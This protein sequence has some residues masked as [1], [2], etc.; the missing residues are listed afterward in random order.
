[1]LSVKTDVSPLRTLMQNEES[2]SGKMYKKEYHVCLLA[3]HKAKIFDIHDALYTHLMELHEDTEGI[4]VF[5]AVLVFKEEE[6]PKP[7]LGKKKI[8]DAFTYRY[9]SKIFVLFSGGETQELASPSEPL[10]EGSKEMEPRKI[11]KDRKQ[12]LHSRPMTPSVI[13]INNPSKS[14]NIVSSPQKSPESP[15]QKKKVY[16]CN[17]CPKEFDDEWKMMSHRNFF[18]AR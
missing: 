17:Q 8:V 7:N 18:H 13:Q 6:T 16:R 15:G 5:M 1:M 12:L 9:D 2:S 3:E 10:P 14:S 11:R 4:K